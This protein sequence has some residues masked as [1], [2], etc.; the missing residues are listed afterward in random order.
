[1]DKDI[2][3]MAR[4][5]YG[6]A[7]GEYRLR[8]GGI[9]SLIAVGNVVMNRSRLS[10]RS[11][12]SEC[13]KPYQFSCWNLGDPNRKV[14]EEVTTSDAIYKKCFIVSSNIICEELYGDITNGA[15]HYYS[16]HLRSPPYWA[17]DRQPTAQI[18]NHIFFNLYENNVRHRSA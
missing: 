8:N 15:T 2:E 13:L 1:M 16:K 7:R 11:V 5:I 10:G 6:E 3:I 12:A 4:T 18:G 14:I 17:V 9:N